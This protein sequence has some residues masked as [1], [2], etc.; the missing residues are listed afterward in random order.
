MRTYL[1]FIRPNF[2]NLIILDVFF[3]LLVVVKLVFVKDLNWF[4]VFSSYIT[5]WVV[6]TIGYLWSKYK[7]Y[8]D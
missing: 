7:G 4:F 2:R 6:T 3:L 5:Y 8:V 1:Q